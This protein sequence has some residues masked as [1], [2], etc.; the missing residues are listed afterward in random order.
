MTS[1]TYTITNRT[2]GLCLGAY[3]A[4]TELD[5]VEAMAI[6]AGYA[7]LDRMAD[8]LGATVDALVA[9][10]RITAVASQSMEADVADAMIALDCAEIDRLETSD[11]V[12]AQAADGTLDCEWSDRDIATMLRDIGT[13]DDDAA[14][15]KVRRVYVRRMT[16]EFAV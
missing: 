12:A 14:I 11:V 10:L 1:T 9:D 15:A 3:S 7:S 2:S 6:D 13:S 16:R 8:A 5:A 4:S